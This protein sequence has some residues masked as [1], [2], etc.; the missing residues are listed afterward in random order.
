MGF[1]S[2]ETRA[3]VSRYARREGSVPG[4]LYDPLD[5]YVT[6][7]R[8]ERERTLIRCLRAAAMAPLGDKRVLEVGCG[9]GSNLIELLRLGFQPYNLVGNELQEGRAEQARQ[10]LPTSVTILT[11][12]ARE[13]GLENGSFDIVYQSTV[14]TS[15]LDDRFQETLA[16]RMWSLVRPGGGVLWYDFTWN[17]PRNPDVR[18]IPF[19]RVRRL[20]DEGVIR[21]WPIT[22]APP[23]GR[24]LCRMSPRLYPAA[25]AL[26]F[27][28]SHLLCW[29]GKSA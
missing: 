10:R 26:P 29:I 6:M 7:A 25:N 23:I 22:L 3:I 21:R 9:M 19:A 12:D 16:R 2:D 5:P 8:Q 17:N 28:R 18:G 13:L 24:P 4:S 20:F 11:G 14:F 1:D 27:L 15:I